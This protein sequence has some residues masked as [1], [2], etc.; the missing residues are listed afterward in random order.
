[1]GMYIT[2]DPQGQVWVQR[3]QPEV[4][5]GVQPVVYVGVQERIYVGVHER[6]IL[7]SIL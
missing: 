5:V 1:M 6:P 3:V 4:C 2:S 7:G